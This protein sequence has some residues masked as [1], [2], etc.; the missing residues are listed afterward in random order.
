MPRCASSPNLNALSSL[1]KTPP[2]VQRVRCHTN[3]VSQATTSSYGV[4][5]D[6]APASRICGPGHS[7]ARTEEAAPAHRTGHKAPKPRRIKIHTPHSPRPT[8][9]SFP[10]E[11]K[12]HPGKAGPPVFHFWSAFPFQPP[13]AQ[14]F[15]QDG[16]ERRRRRGA[17]LS[18]RNGE[19]ECFSFWLGGVLTDSTARPKVPRVFLVVGFQ[20]EKA[21]CLSRPVKTVALRTP[22]GRRR[23]VSAGSRRAKTRH[24]T[25]AVHLLALLCGGG[26]HRRG[27]VAAVG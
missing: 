4:F 8:Q 25:E 14:D 2:C 6:Q 17:R 21:L 11:P 20:I 7:T 15:H 16:I 13:E 26:L 12:D 24:G 3:D 27:I 23:Y 22:I 10:I 18:R 9:P 5:T 1:P 19:G